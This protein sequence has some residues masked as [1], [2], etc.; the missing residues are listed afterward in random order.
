MQFDQLTA[1]LLLANK[2]GDF[3]EEEL[4][5]VLTCCSFEGKCGKKHSSPSAV[6]KEKALPRAAGR[7]KTPTSFALAWHVQKHQVSLQFETKLFPRY[8]NHNSVQTEHV[9][10]PLDRFPKMIFVI[11]GRAEAVKRTRIKPA[12][13]FPV[14][15]TV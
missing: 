7:W 10:R 1:L 4:L 3:D 12:V 9:K 13:L 15:L 6:R 2:G 14:L 5:F 8:G 11:L